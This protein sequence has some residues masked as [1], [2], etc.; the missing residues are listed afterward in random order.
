MTVLID[1]ILATS[2]L[3]CPVRER[4]AESLGD[5]CVVAGITAEDITV[6]DVALVPAAIA[7]R[8]VETH[9]IDRSVAV[10]HDGI[11]MTSLWTPVRADEIEEEAVYLDSVGVASET[12][13]RALL[14]PYFGIVSTG[15]T[16]VDTAPNEARVI[17]R[18]GAAA[19]SV[20]EEGFR[21]DLARTWFILTGMPFV[22]HVT[23]VGVRA[24]ARDADE[25]LAVLR[26]LV[27]TG[28]ERRRDV[29]R[30]IHESTGI[31][32]ETLAEVTGRMRYHLEPEDAEAARRLVEMGTWGTR[33]GRSLP[34]YR[35]QLGSQESGE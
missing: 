4:W 20:T 16:P 26:T 27:E 35:D 3:T 14:K 17:V 22:S 23:V 24:L 32:R 10:V 30:M 29:R 13:A 31:D 6:D 9:V 1:D 7:T 21:E 12:L 28:H 34:A 18:E 5:M 33:F 2:F 25:Q 8:L 11:G 15:V 19:L